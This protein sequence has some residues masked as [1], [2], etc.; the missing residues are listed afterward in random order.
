MKVNLL[1]GIMLFASLAPMSAT[2][3][4]TVRSDSDTIKTVSLDEVKVKAS[5]VVQKGDRT[6]IFITREMRR[7][8]RSVGE[9]LGNEPNFFFDRGLNTLTYNNSSNIVLLVDSIEKDLSTLNMQHIRYDYVEIV[10]H[11]TGK[12]DGYDV[13]INLHTKQ[14]YEGYEGFVYHN[15]GLFL[16]KGRNDPPYINS[17]A[18]I[19]YTRN[20]LTFS[21]YGHFYRGKGEYDKWSEQYYKLNGLRNTVVPSSDGSRTSKF[22]EPRAQTIVSGDYKFDK[23][24]SLSFSYRYNGIW[25]KMSDS[26][27]LLRSYDDGRADVTLGANSD[28]YKQRNE[29][30]FGVFYKDNSSKV[31][32]SANVHYRFMP[33]K[34]H[35]RMAETTGYSTDNNFRD[36]MHFLTYGLD[37]WTYRC[38]NRLYMG[39]GYVGTWKSYLRRDRNTDAELNSNSY[40]RNRMWATATYTV[41]PKMTLSATAWAEH[42]HS[43]SGSL[44]ENSMPFGGNMMLFLRMTRTNWM[45]FNYDCNVAYPD[46]EMS[47]E[48]AYFTDSLTMNSG[49]PLLKSNVTHNFRYWF[50]VWNCFNVQTGLSISPN[51]FTYVTGTAEGTLPSGNRGMYV[52][53]VWQNGDFRNWWASASFTKR[54]LKNFVYKADVKYSISKASWQG[55]S[56]SGRGLTASTSLNY[57]WPSQKMSFFVAYFYQRSFSVSPQSHAKWNFEYPQIYI[58]RT[59]FKDKLDVTLNYRAMF[60]FTNCT[61]HSYTDSPA[62]YIHYYDNTYN[63]QTNNLLIQLRY[64]FSG[65]KSVRQF[66]HEISNEE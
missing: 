61:K 29:H 31:K 43:K 46:Q 15:T 60:R 26:M 27:T 42:I 10:N 45:R 50:D 20:K 66:K 1:A 58:M 14:N 4:L 2:V 21:A 23:Y 51:T 11:P 24:R 49:N 33:T 63:R 48:Y 13:L 53:N 12:Y 17:D 47:S 22:D 36:R 64:R 38:N 5:N 54:F 56:N 34:N 28:S 37:G 3:S 57:Y 25:D 39:A 44:S 52:V 41:S 16:S 7:G 40:L 18:S 8:T 65:G 59:F 30:A 32:Y 9:M 55:Y 6:K 62:L 19:T 35:G